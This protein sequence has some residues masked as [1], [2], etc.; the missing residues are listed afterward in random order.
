MATN[1]SPLRRAFGLAPLACRLPLKGGVM[2]DV[3]ARTTLWGDVRDVMGAKA[4]IP[5]TLA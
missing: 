1:Y 2:R 4:V 3:L 5:P